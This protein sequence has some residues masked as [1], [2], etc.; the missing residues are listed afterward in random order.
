MHRKR[1]AERAWTAYRCIKSTQCSCHV[2]SSLLPLG[3]LYIL[4]YICGGMRKSEARRD[5]HSP[6][7]QY[8]Q[9]RWFREISCLCGRFTSKEEKGKNKEIVYTCYLFFE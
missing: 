6:A 9:P 2:H 4:D 5:L 7:S 3:H 1:S 8:A